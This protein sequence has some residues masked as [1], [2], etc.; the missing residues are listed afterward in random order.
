MK[1][2]AMAAALAVC[3]SSVAFAADAVVDEVVIVDEAFD[4]S[5]LYVG[6][7]VGYGWASVEYE[8]IFVPIL[9]ADIGAGFD[10][11][12]NGIVGGVQIGFN[13]QLGR[14]VL[15][16]EADLQASDVSGSVGQISNTVAGTIDTTADYDLKWFGTLRGR[17]GITAADRLLLYGTAGIAVGEAENSFS[18][19]VDPVFGPNYGGG[20]SGSSTLHGW[21]AGAGAEYAFSDNWSLKGEYLYVDLG[22]QVIDRLPSPFSGP[23]ISSDLS[24]QTVR[25]GVNYRF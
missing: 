21:T 6:A 7:N 8:G 5:G 17:V 13:Q 15:G 2:L 16:V 3:T 9:G 14:F 20:T 23:G 25:L 22:M 24:F 19:I 11:D 10:T 1:Q 18:F 4:W 12:P